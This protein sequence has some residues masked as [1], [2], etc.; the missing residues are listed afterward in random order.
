[1]W[2]VCRRLIVAQLGAA[3]ALTVVELGGADSNVYQRFSDDFDVLAYHAVD[4]NG[5]GLS[6]LKRRALSV[7]VHHHDLLRVALPVKADVVL[8]T[9]LVEHFLPLGTETAIAQHFAHCK[10]GGLVLLSFPRPTPMYW[11]TRWVAT[12]IGMFSKD[13][14]ER[15]LRRREVAPIVERYGELL[16]YETVWSVGLTQSVVLCRKRADA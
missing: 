16:A 14:Y 1:M 4:Q 8:S 7:T 6:R 11:L 15:P 5:A 12:K 9:G 13:L 3:Q 2:S 10:P